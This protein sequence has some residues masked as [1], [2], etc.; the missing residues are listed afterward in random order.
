[1]LRVRASGWLQLDWRG[2]GMGGLWRGR[3]RHAGTPLSASPPAVISP[4]LAKP[5]MPFSAAFACCVVPTRAPWRVRVR[6][7]P[8]T[9][10]R[11]RR[12]ARDQQEVPGHGRPRQ[13]YAA[14]IL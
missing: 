14:R 5:R 10:A 11:G 9:A 7:L 6:A 1:M 2:R 12:H 4:P 13:A 8:A 3:Q